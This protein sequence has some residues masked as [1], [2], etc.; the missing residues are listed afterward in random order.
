[1]AIITISRGTH[2]GGME[3]AK[4]V[5]QKLN[6]K[7]VSREEIVHRAADFGIS[8]K[9]LNDILSR[10]P[11][12][13]ERFKKPK[14][15][16]LTF[17]KGALLDEAIKNNVV[18]HGLAGHLLLEDDCCILKVKL[19]A[20]MG[21]RIERTMNIHNF[22][23]DEAVKYIYDQD[24]NRF[25]WTK[26]LYNKD[27]NNSALYDIVLNLNIIDIETATNAITSIA[28]DSLFKPN[29]TNNLK[30]KNCYLASK[31]EI[32]LLLEKDTCDLNISID[33]IDDGIV[34]LHGTLDN[35]KLGSKV[36]DIASKVDGVKK[37]YDKTIHSLAVT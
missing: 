9:I 28:N 1:M 21:F 15:K 6:Y 17:L 4:S 19:I 27:W 2:S 11:S 14:T 23:Q 34:E 3:I 25:K 12:F 31:I 10:A 18:Y 36:I 32:A 37:V 8:E 35:K 24:E 30:I 20:N 22:S 7:C 16:Y 13:W 33:V 29:E 26:F 5:A